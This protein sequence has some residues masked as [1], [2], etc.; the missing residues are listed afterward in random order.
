MILVTGATGDTGRAVIR[1]LLAA[2]ASVRAMVRRA[3][4]AGIF[5]TGVDVVVADMGRADSLPAAVEGIDQMLLISPLDPS[6]VEMQ[7]RMAAVARS[8]GVRRI[9][10]ISTEIADPRSEASI[11]R[12]HGLA[13]RE[14]EE[15]G[16]AFFHLRPCNFM[17]NL[18]TFTAE[19]ASS[20]S[21]S[22]PLGAAR[23]SLVDVG[24]LAAVAVAA[25]LKRELRSGF[26]VVTGG[27]RPTYA[28][29]ADLLS[30]ALGRP[31][32]HLP[33]APQDALKHFLATGMPP[34]KANELVRMYAYLQDP[35]HTQTTDTVPHFTG[36]NPR[37]FQHF[38]TEYAARLA[39]GEN[40]HG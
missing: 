28:E 40:Q 10:K 33:V 2:G 22:S 8:G 14:V 12:W 30:T 11:G 20:N 18:Y 13:E 26:T 21:F 32:R 17:Q 3:E 38:V 35:L 27:D 5:P 39:A 24:D 34:W 36:R 25:L 19:I 23:I 1:G 15:T 37:E 4:Q 31:V 16:L 9:V 29:F 7:G 6:L